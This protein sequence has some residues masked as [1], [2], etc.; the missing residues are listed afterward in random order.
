MNPY[1]T[2]HAVEGHLPGREDVSSLRVVPLEFKLRQLRRRRRRA[3][4]RQLVIGACWGLGLLGVA[5][6][7]I[8]LSMTAVHQ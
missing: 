8:A 7:A 3:V 2:R 1:R 6:F 5:A 4:L